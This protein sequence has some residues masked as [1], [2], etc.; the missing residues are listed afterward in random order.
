M[1]FVDMV[2]AAARQRG[3]RETAALRDGASRR[4]SPKSSNVGL[5]RHSAL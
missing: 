5:A 2:V 1:R 3:R 4:G